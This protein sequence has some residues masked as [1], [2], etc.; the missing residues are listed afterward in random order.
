M[1]NK[2]IQEYMQ[3]NP[4]WYITLSRYPEKQKEL[5]ALFKEDTKGT[6]SDKL[7]K[8]SMV[9]SMMDMLM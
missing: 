3:E 8:I 4:S 9:L 1:M 5:E 2:T 7:D 6:V